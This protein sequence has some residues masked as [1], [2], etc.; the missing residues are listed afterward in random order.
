TGAEVE[1]RHVELTLADV[2]ETDGPGNAEVSVGHRRTTRVHQC[3]AVRQTAHH[4]HVRVPGHGNVHRAPEAT[5]EQSRDLFVAPGLGE[6]QTVSQA[7]AEAIDVRDEG[8]DDTR[9]LRHTRATN[10]GSERVAV[11]A[12]GDGGCQPLEAVD[13]IDRVHVA[14]V[15]DQ[16]APGE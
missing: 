8:V 4:R 6:P 7:D 3:S 9:I 16:V 11:A 12:R 1:D 15:Q 2:D 10:P 13:D 14:A 5:D